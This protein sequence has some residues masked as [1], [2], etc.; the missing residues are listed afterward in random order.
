MGSGSEFGVV[1]VRANASVC[2]GIRLAGGS[3]LNSP[4]IIIRVIKNFNTTFLL[5]NDRLRANLKRYLSEVS[6]NRSTATTTSS[7]SHQ[8]RLI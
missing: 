3:D 5:R 1:L 7:K 2:W 4:L 8:K 6:F